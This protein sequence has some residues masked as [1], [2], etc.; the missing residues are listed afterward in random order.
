MY[1]FAYFKTNAEALH[2]ALSSDCLLWRELNKGKPLLQGSI[3]TKTLRD[4]FIMRD[5]LGRYQLLCTDGW[6]SP[7]LIHA[8][9]DNLIEW[10]EQRSIGVMQ[11]VLGTRNAW[12][13]EALFDAAS[14]HYLVYW[15]STVDTDPTSQARNHRLWYVRTPDFVSFSP[16]ALLF[17]PGYSVIDSTIIAYKGRFLMVFKDEREEHKGLRSCWAPTPLGP[18]EALSEQFTPRLVEGPS[19][20]LVGERL[21]C[22]CDFY[23]AGH[24]GSFES[25]DGTNWSDSSATLQMPGHPRHGSIVKIDKSHGAALIERFGLSPP[26]TH[27][28]LH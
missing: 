14:G 17:D 16:P 25:N 10:S 8:H 6:A 23:G 27:P 11:G 1:A 24:Y 13:P 2:L 4:P 28:A 18:W 19:L 26:T 5:K 22:L 15:S 21:I 9:S 20:A 3:A 7:Q 12:A